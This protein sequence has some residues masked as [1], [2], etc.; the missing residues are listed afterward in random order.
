[1]DYQYSGCTV[2]LLSYLGD[3]YC[4]GDTYNTPECGWDG[5]DCCSYSCRN[6]RFTCGWAGYDCQ[7]PDSNPYSTLVFQLSSTSTLSSETNTALIQGAV[8]SLLEISDA[9]QLSFTVQPATDEANTYLVTAVLRTSSFESASSVYRVENNLQETL[10]DLLGGVT[11]VAASASLSTNN[12]EVEDAANQPVNVVGI[13]VG[14]VVAVV[15]IAAII[16]LVVYITNKGNLN[17]HVELQ[18]EVRVCVCVCVCVVCVCVCVCACV[19]V[20]VCGVRC[21]RTV[22]EYPTR[23]AVQLGCAV[24]ASLTI[25]F[26]VQSNLT[27]CICVRRVQQTTAPNVYQTTDSAGDGQANI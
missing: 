17:K 1:M 4:D 23:S 24:R 10:Q 26:N 20:R 22:L 14:V 25:E 5:G 7:D 18:E 12:G 16:V 13:V 15:L 11:V 9:A 2:S 27:Y 21:V 3:G 8:L 6:N 19:R